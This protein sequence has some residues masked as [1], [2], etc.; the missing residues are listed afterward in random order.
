MLNM[1][2]LLAVAVTAAWLMLA[3]ASSRDRTRRFNGASAAWLVTRPAER[4]DALGP[5]L[6]PDRRGNRNAA[7]WFLF[8][9]AHLRE[10]RIGD[11]ARAFG[12]AHHADYRVESAAL[13]TFACLKASAADQSGILKQII[14]TWD[15][16]GCPAV[17]ERRAERLLFDCLESTTR[18]LPEL[19]P[20]G[21]LAWLVVGADQQ[22]GIERTI[23]EGGSRWADAMRADQGQSVRD[24]DV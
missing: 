4:V 22:S 14:D 16:M 18:D 23:R 10:G 9:C 17:A 12:V 11:A 20:I 3:V 5:Y 2:L 7:A 13:L 24:S 19:S 21:R 8:G 1:L 15:E 6:T